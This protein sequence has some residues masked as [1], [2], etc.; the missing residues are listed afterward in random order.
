MTPL[1][2]WRWSHNALVPMYVLYLLDYINT[3]YLHSINENILRFIFIKSESKK[4]IAKWTK[5][6]EAAAKKAAK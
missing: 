1:A 6:T 5:Q 3:H 2:M 4:E